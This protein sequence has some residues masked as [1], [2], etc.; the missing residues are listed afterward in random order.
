VEFRGYLRMNP[1]FIAIAVVI[2]ILVAI[3]GFTVSRSSL[4]HA[5]ELEAV[6][7]ADKTIARIGEPLNFTSDNCKGD[8]RSYLWDFGDG[9]SSTE[10]NPKH[11]Y[12][13]AGWY[14]ATLYLE[15]VEGNKA[16]STIVIGIQYNNI[17][18]ENDAPREYTSLRDPWG[19]GYSA[20]ADVGYAIGK[21]T[22]VIH[23]EVINAIGSFYFDISIMYFE[24]YEKRSGSGTGIYSEFTRAL[25][26]DLTFDYVVQP[27][28]IPNDIYYEISEI[29][30]DI[31]V[32]EGTWESAVITMDVT[33]PVDDVQPFY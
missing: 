16:N 4:G 2:I 23:A 8:I 26:F 29:W 24:D 10:R 14:N 3:I 12:E 32:S 31:V 17:Y 20:R 15:C 19:L 21:P 9:N 33:F 28:E 22:A 25:R 1:K 5:E 6:P 30:A 11:D 7:E 18:I 13:R 27:S